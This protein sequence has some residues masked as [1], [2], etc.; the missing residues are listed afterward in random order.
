MSADTHRP[1]RLPAPDFD[2]SATLESGQVFHFTR[3]HGRWWGVLGARAVWM[4]QQGGTVVTSEWAARRVS[5][6]LA[7]DH[8]MDLIRASFPAEDDRL[9][10]AWAFAPGLRILRQPPWECLA[11]FI[12]SSMK[13][14]AHIR[15][16][17]L[18]LR[19]RFG[20][21]V[22]TR[23]D[24]F[25][26][27][28]YPRAEVL[29]EVGESALRVCGL[30]YRARSLARVAEAVAERRVD[31][32]AAGRLGTEELCRVLEGLHGVGPKIAAC[33]ALF[34]YGR[35]EVFPI[36]TWTGRVLAAYFP[37][38]PPRVAEMI[39]FTR[40]HFGPYAGYAQQALFHHARVGGGLR[41]SA[42]IV[43]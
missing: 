11:T 12:T 15:A 35:L 22:G 32:A 20:R 40:E 39:H 34:G 26:L 1:A 2:L 36:D 19:R 17:S 28:A 16:L 25:P 14:V 33:V 24:G 21:R 23:P 9:A 38:K 43:P 27:H 13:Q 42:A 37:G 31:L 18:E 3:V 41:P 5:R 4:T 30:G 6:F 10:E 7:L 29:A 8:S